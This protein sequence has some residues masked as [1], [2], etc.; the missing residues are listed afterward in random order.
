MKD[1]RKELESE[2]KRLNESTKR[3]IQTRG[4]TKEVDKLKMLEELIR[5]QLG[6]ENFICSTS[7]TR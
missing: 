2:L 7:T 3:L 5:E 6:N 4:Y 1:K